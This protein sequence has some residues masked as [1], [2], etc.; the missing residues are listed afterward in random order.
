M[1]KIKSKNEEVT[2]WDAIGHLPKFRPSLSE[3]PKRQN[4]RKVSHEPVKSNH[5]EIEDNHWPRFQNERDIK[6]FKNWVENDMNRR[7]SEEKLAFYNK[8]LGKSS[9]HSKYRNLEKDKPSQTIV[10]HLYKDGLLFIHPE[11]DQARSISVKE[12]AL[13]QSFPEDFRFEESMGNNFKMIGNAVPPLM[14]KHI[15]IAIA[16]VLKK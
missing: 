4:G 13:L 3:T 6:I 5:K 11:A 8:M 10:A 9:N 2:V 15:A 12:A 14:A 7:G 16:E 1:Q